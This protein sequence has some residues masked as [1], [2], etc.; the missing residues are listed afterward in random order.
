MIFIPGPATKLLNIIPKF[1]NEIFRTHESPIRLKRVK[2]KISSDMNKHNEKRTFQQT[3]EYS[4]VM[5]LNP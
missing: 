1:Q 4:V 5:D 2:Q 3:K